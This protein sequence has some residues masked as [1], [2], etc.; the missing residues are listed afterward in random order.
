[1]LCAGVLC[2]GGCVGRGLERSFWAQ[3]GESL[4]SVKARV[5]SNALDRGGPGGTTLQ[6]QLA[7]TKLYV[8]LAT[9]TLHVQLD[10]APV[11]LA[12]ASVH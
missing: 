8:Q 1:M 11:S 12:T 2:A 4:E 6:V 3:E 7:T 5:D 10:S 9:T